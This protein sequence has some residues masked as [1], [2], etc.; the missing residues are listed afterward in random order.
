M[1][2]SW[3]RRRVIGCVLLFGFV[4]GCV[5]FHRYRPVGVLVRDAETKQPIA[6]ATV[7]VSYS[8]GPSPMAPSGPPGQTGADGLVRLPAALF[9]DGLTLEAT[10]AGYQSEN[11][12]VSLTAIERIEPPPLFGKAK[13]RPADFVVEMY[14]QPA[15][16]VELILP[17]AYR[18]LVK[19]EVQARD[20]V[21]LP[22]GQRCFRYEVSPAGEVQVRGPAVIRRV[23]PP[24][25]RARYENGEELPGEMSVTKLGFRWLK[26]EG[27]K[28]YFVVGTENEY[29]GYRRD[30]Q[31]D[32]AGSEGRSSPDGKAG[33][34]GGRHRHSDDSSSP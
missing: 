29:D 27:G 31:S 24:S 15:F 4:A 2:L 23:F 1:L 34:R 5:S 8:M 3:P 32:A 16:S 14:A 17:I 25:F 11:R 18:G 6:S 12:D 22:A 19:V 28:Q 20:D 21:P 30:L 7:R 10:A 26:Q 33:G 9:G 13:E